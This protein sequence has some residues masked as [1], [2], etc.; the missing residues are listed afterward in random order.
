MILIS[1]GTIGIVLLYEQVRSCHSETVYALLH[2][3]NHE[4]VIYSLTMTGYTF[5]YIL[6]KEITVLILVN[7]YLPVLLRDPVA[8][9][10]RDT[11]SLVVI[12][13]AHHSQG[14]LCYIREVKYILVPLSLKQPVP[15]AICYPYQ[16]AHEIS[17]ILLLQ[18]YGIH[19]L[20]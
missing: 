9:N 16:R 17:D 12:A 3:S 15:V 10:G 13:V 7:E 2:I 8:H 19:I 20:L 1:R 14:K 5:D 4:H 18:Q 6:L 11:V